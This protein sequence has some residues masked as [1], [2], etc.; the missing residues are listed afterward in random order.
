MSSMRQEPKRVVYTPYATLYHHESATRG[1][2]AGT[3]VVF[4]AFATWLIPVLVAAGWRWG[5]DPSE[6]TLLTASGA[7]FVAVVL[8]QMANAFACRSERLPAWRMPPRSNE[9][10]V[11]A[12]GVELVALAAFLLVPPLANTLELRPPTL[13]GGGLA[14]IAVPAVLVADAVHKALRRPGTKVSVPAPP[15]LLP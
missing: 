8:G 9:L 3:S 15:G 13:L 1:L 4:W 10:L 6:A 11:A 7:A 12:V 5:G 14:L 2:A